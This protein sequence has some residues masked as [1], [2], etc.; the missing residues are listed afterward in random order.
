MARV[1]ATDSRVRRTLWSAGSR[2]TTLRKEKRPSRLVAESLVLN[3]EQ[4]RLQSPR[5]ARG[6]VSSEGCSGSAWTSSD[7]P[8]TGRRH[9]GWAAREGL[10]GRDVVVVHLVAVNQYDLEPIASDQERL[11][12]RAS[13]VMPGT[14]P[15]L[16]RMA[17]APRLAA[18]PRRSRA[19]CDPA[20]GHSRRSAGIRPRHES[21]A[22]SMVACMFHVESC[23]HARWRT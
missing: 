9:D 3:G 16:E 12:A 10:Q 6:D 21:G 23:R 15:R 1:S 19:P 11:E 14:A 20:G 8:W 5:D 2:V 22:R 4:A 7:S 18:R 13:V 17:D